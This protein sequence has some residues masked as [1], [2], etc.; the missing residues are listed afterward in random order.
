MIIGKFQYQNN[1][2]CYQN[3]QK[4]KNYMTKK[5]AE[6][7]MEILITKRKQKFILIVVIL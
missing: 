4:I 6:Y 2:I 3:F 1:V 5:H 7:V